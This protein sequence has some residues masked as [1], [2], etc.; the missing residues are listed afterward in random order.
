MLEYACDNGY[1]YFDFGRS[2]PDEGTYKFKKQW[3]ATPQPL[4]WYDISLTGK[5]APEKETEKSKFS[6]AI[7]YW[8]KLPVSVTGFLGP[9]IRKHIGL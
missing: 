7:Q 8:Q 3:G 9:M 1:K 4:H 2:T 6:R 5:P